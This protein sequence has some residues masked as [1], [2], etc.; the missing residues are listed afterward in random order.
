[1]KIFITG[2]P[3]C[4]KTTLLKEISQILKEWG[5]VF[6]GFITDEVRKGNTRTG[7]TIQD[8]ATSEKLIFASTD[9]VTP[10]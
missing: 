1:M 5:I 10:Y 8:L 4:G 9:T 3:S 2:N 6:T 7:F